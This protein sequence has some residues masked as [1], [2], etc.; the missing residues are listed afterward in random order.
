M[1]YRRRA[2]VH[3]PWARG[4]MLRR[5]RCP[6]GATATRGTMLL[7]VTNLHVAYGAITALHGVSL[8]IDRGEIV[9]L[10]G[11]N[12][13][14]KTTLLRAISGLIKVV[15]GAIRWQDNEELQNARPDQIVRA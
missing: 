7:S 11:A 10:I 5:N 1:A 3:A 15:D 4:A 12:G 2:C 9:A 6:F 8:E 14:G 13:A